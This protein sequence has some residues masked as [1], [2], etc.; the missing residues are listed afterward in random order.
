MPELEQLIVAGVGAPHV[1]ETPRATRT[2]RFNR[3]G[4]AKKNLEIATGRPPGG[5]K[6]PGRPNG[7]RKTYHISW[8]VGRKYLVLDIVGSWR[9]WCVFLRN[10]GFTKVRI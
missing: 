4:E 10:H 3:Y 5:Q 1:L 6:G 7:T 2:R 9:A 8:T